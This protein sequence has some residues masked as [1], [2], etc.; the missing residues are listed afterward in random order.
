MNCC[1]LCVFLLFFFSSCSLLLLFFFSSSSLLLLFFFSS[2]S[3][4]LLLPPPFFFLLLLPFFLPFHC[5]IAAGAGTAHGQAAQVHDWGREQLAQRAG[6]PGLRQRHQRHCARRP[7]RDARHGFQA[8]PQDVPGAREREQ[9]RNQRRGVPRRL[10]ALARR[11]AHRRRL[12]VPLKRK[13][14]RKEKRKKKKKE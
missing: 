13:K 12:H 10:Q 8:L 14:G 1:L 2:S 9:H 7:A 11:P 6:A 3:F 4:L 5:R